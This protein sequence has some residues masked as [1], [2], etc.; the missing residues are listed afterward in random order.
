MES[1]ES[2]IFKDY[3]ICDELLKI[4]ELSYQISFKTIYQHTDDT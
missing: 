3:Y 2:Y 4:T 1:Y